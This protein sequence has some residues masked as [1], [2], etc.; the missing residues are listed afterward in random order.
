MKT[1]PFK[2]ERHFDRYEF[3]APFLLCSSDCESLH[4]RGLMAPEPAARD[5]LDALW[6]GYTEAP[7]NPELRQT[8]AG[9]PEVSGR[10]PTRSR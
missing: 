8:I 5:Q 1:A 4:L 3:T 2:L 7:G 10:A 6:L 9:L